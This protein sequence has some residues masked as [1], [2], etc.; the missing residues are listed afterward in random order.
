MNFLPTYSLTNPLKKNDTGSCRSSGRSFAVRI[1]R[2]TSGRVAGDGELK[3]NTNDRRQDDASHGDRESQQGVRGRRPSQTR[4]SGENGKVQRRAGKGGHHA[5]G[6]GAPRELERQARQIRGRKAHG[7]RWAF[8]GIEGTGSRLLA[9][10]G[11]VDG[12]SGRV[13]EARPIRWGS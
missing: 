13:A 1:E 11:E 4:D 2:R 12:R 10:A 5:G 7:D 8:H 3:N 9:L 6:R